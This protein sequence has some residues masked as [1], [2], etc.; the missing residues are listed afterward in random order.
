[1]SRVDTLDDDKWER[2]H[3]TVVSMCIYTLCCVKIDGFLNFFLTFIRQFGRVP[4][5]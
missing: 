3:T 4:V 2:L 5:H 1:M